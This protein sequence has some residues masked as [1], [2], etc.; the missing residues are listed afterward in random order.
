MVWS[1][2]HFGSSSI[3]PS[4]ISFSGRIVLFLVALMADWA[5][6]LSTVDTPSAPEEVRNNA[7]KVFKAAGLDTPDAADGTIEAD[8]SF[9]EVQAPVRALVRRTLRMLADIT[10]AK[11]AGAKAVAQP[12]AESAS[13]SMQDFAKTATVNGMLEALGPDASALSVAQVMAHGGKEVNVQEALDRTDLAKLDYTLHADH[14][15]WQLL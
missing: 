2:S 13:T 7:E 14:S 15:V 4:A 10:E 11:R 9:A 6:F 1:R 5:A 3:Q 8:L 12:S